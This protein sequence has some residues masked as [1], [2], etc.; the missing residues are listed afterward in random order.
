MHDAQRWVL[1]TSA[2]IT[3]SENP[4]SLAALAELGARPRPRNLAVAVVGL[5]DAWDITNTAQ[6]EERFEALMRE[7]DERGFA[8]TMAADLAHAGYGAYLL[9][10]DAAWSWLLRAA[11][12]VQRAF[13][14][15]DDLAASYRRGAVE[16]GDDGDELA[17][18]DAVI[19]RLLADPASPWATLPF[20]LALGAPPAP[21]ETARTLRVEGTIAAT[22]AEARDGDR[23]VVPAGTY[24]ERL[25][26]STP[27]WD[28]GEEGL[29]PRAPCVELVA[30]GRVV[31]THDAGPVIEV[32]DGG[33]VLD[34]VRVENTRARLSDPDEV[35]ADV[36]RV[37]DGA[38]RLARCAVASKAGRGVVTL[39]GAQL[40]ECTV[41]SGGLPAV[42]G[43]RVLVVERTET[44]GGS[45]VVGEEGEGF[46]D[47]CRLSR[48][49]HSGLEVIDG[50]RAVA[51]R[52]AFHE[53]EGAGVGVFDRGRVELQDCSLTKNA[54][55]GLDVQGSR[56]IATDC[57]L[58]DN[59]AS[60][61]LFAKATG[62]ALT[63]CTL[64]GNA[65]AAVL[66][67][68]QA[69]AR[70]VE[71]TVEAHG[72]GGALLFV[73]AGGMV[74]RS[75]ISG[76]PAM[77]AVEVGG[78]SRATLT[79]CTIRGV[80]GEGVFVRGGAAP[81]LLGCAAEGGAF[82][83]VYVEDG[84]P[85]LTGCAISGH[86]KSGVILMKGRVTLR[87]S[88]LHDNAEFGVLVTA[89]KARL[90]AC[91]VTDHG[92]DGVLV[93]GDVEMSGT[94]IARS[95]DCNLRVQEGGHARLTGCRVHH[96]AS[97]GLF[98]NGRGRVDLD[99]CDVFENKEEGVQVDDEA[100][101]TLE[102]SDV[103]ANGLAGVLVRHKA[104]LTVSD[105]AL[106]ALEL[107]GSAR[108]S[109]TKCVVR[110]GVRRSARAK[111]T[112]KGC[113]VGVDRPFEVPAPAKRRAKKGGA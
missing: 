45:V 62:N 102:R 26:V 66:L 46:L 72:T 67:R 83:G 50:A 2:I 58:S 104:T 65:N 112:T 55:S 92:E 42:F 59:G 7:T 29:A 53:N 63:R 105:G 44:S 34:G 54:F 100:R 60:G 39:E 12:A 40:V 80:G 25:R 56:A 113:A 98:A 32:D 51:A 17:A 108:A 30:E 85:T 4:T 75:T 106:D 111:L 43:S 97:V 64:R 27:E 91:A 3:L 13:R 78:R 94:E 8:L 16:R 61:A 49:A 15:F 9:D 109:L 101:V 79:S 52:C 84:A 70:V 33:L 21:P 36:V 96:G 110:R 90:E 57:T 1:A 69:F 28:E 71:C 87:R 77:T 86:A 74:S 99:A 24:R 47:G 41:E 88:K 19:A 31:L 37:T 38:V 95:K 81:A 6:L 18:L 22:L 10:R 5:A 107:E 103:R 35:D 89:G 20:D 93:E 14:S 23:V 11:R 48:S 76:S 73:D 68:E 82:S